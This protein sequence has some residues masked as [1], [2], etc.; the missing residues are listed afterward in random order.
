MYSIGNLVGSVLAVGLL[1]TIGFYVWKG[2]PVASTLTAGAVA[3]A[4]SLWGRDFKNDAEAIGASVLYLLAACA[5]LPY[6]QARDRKRKAK[7]A[8]AS[9]PPE[10]LPRT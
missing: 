3:A 10:S 5:W 6:W 7:V 2:S 9:A 1:S 8:A 4:L